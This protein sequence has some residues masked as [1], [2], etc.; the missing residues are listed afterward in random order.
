MSDFGRALRAIRRERALS[1]EE[2]ARILGTSK[3]VISRYE[4]GQRI[5]KITIVRD[6][7][8][9]L[10][11]PLGH[12]ADGEPDLPANLLPIRRV[13]VPMIDG[14]AVDKPILSE[15]QYDAYVASDDGLGC[16]CALR[17][18]DDSMEPT[19][20]PGD[21]A[22]LR[23]QNDVD[24]GRIAAVLINERAALRR[25]YHMPGGLQLLSDNAAKYPPRAVTP[26]DR[27]TIR[28]LGLAVAYKRGL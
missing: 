24:D 25:I 27:D 23:L 22:F 1:Q 6:Y 26:E 13:R 12:L 8:N 3:Q 11:V 9:R 20:R 21:I 19:L 7:A 4:N 28:I 16:D 15:Q 17:V 2:L 5:P 14:I 10:G 18:D